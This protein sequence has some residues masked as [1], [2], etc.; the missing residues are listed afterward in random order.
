[1]NFQWRKSSYSSPNG[2]ECV[3][4]AKGTDGVFARDSKDAN[5]PT[6]RFDPDE[7]R[8]FLASVKKGDLG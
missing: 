4:V 7:W 6:L 5:G 3:E 1:M 2:G 8:V